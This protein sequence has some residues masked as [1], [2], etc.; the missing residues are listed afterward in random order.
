[1]VSVV[2]WE[3]ILENNQIV[4]EVIEKASGL[5]RSRE[6]CLNILNVFLVFIISE[7]IGKMVLNIFIWDYD[8]EDWRVCCDK[9]LF[10]E[11]LAC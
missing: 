4:K 10:G 6:S 5:K 8:E 3:T 11:G 1:M 7:L 9:E 2:I